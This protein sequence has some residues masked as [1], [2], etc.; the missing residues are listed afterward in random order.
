MDEIINIGNKSF[1]KDEVIARGQKSINILKNVLRWLGLG[2][3]ATGLTLL[4][5]QLVTSVLI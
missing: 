1:T 2:I 3:A 5:N 4:L